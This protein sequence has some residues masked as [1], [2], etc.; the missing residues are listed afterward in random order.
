L[1]D[2]IFNEVDEEVRREQL[3]KLW[4]RYGLFIIILAVLVVL[5]IG[6]WRG[7]EFWQNREAARAGSAF[8]AALALSEEGKTAEAEKAF[9][10]IA[11]TGTPG[12]QPLAR[13]R[14]AAA[15]AQ[16]DRAE[17]VKLYDEITASPVGPMLQDLAAVRAGFLLVDTADFKELERRLAPLAEPGRPFRHSARELLA[18]SAWKHGDV[19]AARRYVS[20]VNEDND[21][22]QSVRARIE[23]VAALLA[24]S[25][26]PDAKSDAKSDAKQTP[27]PDKKG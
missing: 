26:A 27:S 13:L 23:V 25:G 11:R 4:D 22:P 12:Y 20:L 16:R 1:V 7:Y 9:A 14:V 18:L 6:G 21:T 10:E 2:N 24:A 5:G 8:E 19:T 15:A 17:G 3:K